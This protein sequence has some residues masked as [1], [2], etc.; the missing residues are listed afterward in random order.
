MLRFC[1]I[2]VVNYEA[3]QWLLNKQ[4]FFE[5]DELLIVN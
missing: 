4:G 3:N 1:F 2:D 5:I